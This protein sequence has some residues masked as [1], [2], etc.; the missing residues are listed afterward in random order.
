SRLINQM[1]FL[2]REGR[3]EPE[4]FAIGALIEEAYQDARQHQ[5]SEA[6]RL[7]C[8]SGGKPLI[9]TGDRAALRH[10]LSEVILN[11]LQANP[12]EPRVIVRLHVEPSGEGQEL[13]IEIQDNGPGFTPEAAQKAPAPF[14]T[15][16][17]V[18]NGLGLTV[19][20]KIIEAHQG[21]LEIASP[22]PGQPGIVGISLPMTAPVVAT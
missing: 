14:F 6:A 19:S 3:F 17:T 9:I 16:R 13:K 15:T 22:R 11:A 18:G 12:K 21:R 1:R 20:R 10:A 4:A 5:P 7:E 2:A 8:D